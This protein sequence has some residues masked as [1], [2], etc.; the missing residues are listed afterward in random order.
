MKK[1][2]IN[3]KKFTLLLFIIGGLSFSQAQDSTS[4]SINNY[5]TLIL[6][7]G[8]NLVDSSGE[9][10][11]FYFTSEFDEMA[12]SNN[13]IAEVEYRFSRRFSLAGVVSLNKW[14]KNKG[15]IDNKII[16][17]DFTYSAIDLDFKYYFS[18]D[19]SWIKRVDWLELYLHTGLGLVVVEKSSEVSFN[20]GLGAN[21]WFTDNFGLNLSG[22]AKWAETDPK[23]ATNHFQYSTSLIYRFTDTDFDN[24]GVKNKVDN[25]PNVSGSP[26]NNGCPEENLDRDGDGVAD[27]EDN[28]PDVYG[29]DFGCPL[30]VVELDT[31]GDSVL[32]SVDS[33][34]K[35]VG[36]P[37]NNGCPLPDSDKDGVVD[38]ADACP[39]IPGI[40]SNN[41]CPFE[42]TELI[43][44]LS[45]H[46]YFRVGD[47][48]FTQNSNITLTKLIEFA[49]E[50]PQA[51]FKLSGHTDNSGPE[52]SNMVL[53]QNRVNAVRDYLISNGVSSESLEVSAYGESMP[54]TS[55]TTKEG[56]F[57]NRRVE[58]VMVTD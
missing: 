27:S 26:L 17:K 13:F 52:E 16:S 45:K 18:E 50:Y 2:T 53:S 36:L 46:I 42:A 40:A 57:L 4:D 54:M 30:K 22:T 51:N 9:Q 11:P 31:D 32:D 6:K 25:C 41:G 55:N 19:L 28:C 49:T 38:A 14:K 33:C 39:T 43:D 58:I 23:K 21:F 20:A 56:R 12:F 34:P 44:L 48:N 1:L 24:D 29:T 47:Y 37:S 10:N 8:L 7:F 35:I 15:N 3:M 5:N